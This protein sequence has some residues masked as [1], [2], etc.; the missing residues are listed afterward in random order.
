[1]SFPDCLHCLLCCLP[2]CQWNRRY[3]TILETPGSIFCSKLGIPYFFRCTTEFSASFCTRDRLSSMLRLRHLIIIIFI[4]RCTLGATNDSHQ[5]LTRR[6]AYRRAAIVQ[7]RR[8]EAKF[9]A[10]H[11][12]LRHLIKFHKNKG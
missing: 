10:I 6:L 8:G 3:H 2:F 9:T 1:M 7:L 11:V 4:H 12:A 5:P